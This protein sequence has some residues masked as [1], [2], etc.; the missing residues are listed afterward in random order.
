M[1]SP[2]SHK[3]Q[4]LDEQAVRRQVRRLAKNAEAPWLHTEVAQRMAE[5]LQLIKMQPQACLQWGAWLG[6]GIES[7]QQQ[8]PEAQALWVEPLNA[9][10]Q[11]SQSQ[12]QRS[13]WQRILPSQFRQAPQLLRADDP[14]PCP[15]Q[16]LWSNMVLHGVEDKQGLFKTWHRQLSVDGFVMF[17]LLGPDS[18]VELRQ[19]FAAQ[20]WGASAPAWPDMHD[21]GDML[22]EAG[23]ADPVM[24]QE[25]LRL[26]W[27]SPEKLLTDLRLL[28]GNTATSRFKGLRTRHWRQALLQ[29]LE[30]LRGPE[31][32]IALSVELVYGHAFKPQPRVKLEGEARVSL[33]DM[34]GMLR[35]PRSV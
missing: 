8:Y 18:F 28:G 30:T 19:L 35:K 15:V 31:G 14:L 9:L 13:W 24:D 12:L 26:T 17:A 23:F 5:R 4:D 10:H 6:G 16:L 22:V 33:D 21:L 29:A 2:P 32:V 34:R 3:L 1:S 11:R 25:R 7:L 20:G 27:Q